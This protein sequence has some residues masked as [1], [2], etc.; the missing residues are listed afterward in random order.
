MYSWV[1]P[2]EC[3]NMPLHHMDCKT[4]TGRLSAVGSSAKSGR[5]QD[6]LRSHS[7]RLALDWGC[8]LAHSLRANRQIEA[9][10]IR[11]RIDSQDGFA[12]LACVVDGRCDEKF[13]YALTH[14]VWVHPKRPQFPFISVGFD[15]RVARQTPVAC[16]CNERRK[17]S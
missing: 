9:L 16:F 7:F 11:V 14:E 5:P 13:A 10:R 8:N 15:L 2:S 3:S 4:V 17:Q 1:D 12:V 6:K